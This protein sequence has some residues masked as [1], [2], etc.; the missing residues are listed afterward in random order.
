LT[1]VK[2]RLLFTTNLEAAIN[3]SQKSQKS[4]IEIGRSFTTRTFEN[5]RRV[6]QPKIGVFFVI[7][8][9]FCLFANLAQSLLLTPIA[10]SW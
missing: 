6:D 9:Q 8:S 4:F 1:K 10:Y 5:H 3:V 7:E 2:K